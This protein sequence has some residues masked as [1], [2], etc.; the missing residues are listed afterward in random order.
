MMRALLFCVLASPLFGQSVTATVPVATTGNVDLPW[1]GGVGRYQQWYSAASLQGQIPEPMRIERVSFFAG[2]SLTS[3]TTTIQCE[4]LLGHGFASGV[5]GL[6]ANNFA[7]TPQMVVPLT[8][9]TLTAGTPGS[10]VIDVPFVTK[11][12]WDRV[13]PLVLEVR[14]HANGQGS[15]PFTYNFLGAPAATGQTTRVYLGGSTTGTLGTSQQGVGL[16][17]RFTARPGVLLDF[18]AGCPGGGGVVPVNTVQQI[19]S[20]G[21]NWGHQLTNAGSQQIALWV[22]GTSTTAWDTIPLP[23]DLALFWGLPPSGCMLRT[24][25][26]WTGAYATVGGG[27]G[28]GA[29]QFNW[30]LPAIT[31]YVGLS[32]YTQWIV[33]DEFAPNG[34]LSTTQGV[35]CICAPLG[36]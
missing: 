16:I 17:T 30:Q 2:S 28:T 18:G 15:Q 29:V 35:R 31:S 22:M 4:I 1:A 36:G 12:T 23:V 13:R 24:D 14:I 33:F 21:I 25:P 9:I 26:I 32:F 5:T 3:I 8:T 11:F 19:M 6:F 34:L 27:P 7:T 10:I 20:P